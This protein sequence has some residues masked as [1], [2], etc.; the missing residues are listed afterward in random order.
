MR[1]YFDSKNDTFDIR[2]EDGIE[3]P[4]LKEARAQATRALGSILRDL[5]GEEETGRL[6]VS[7]RTADRPEPIIK[8]LLFFDVSESASA[9]DASAHAPALGKDG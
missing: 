7:V 5:A 6:L 3:L 8:A 9:S 2:D 1:F 4:G